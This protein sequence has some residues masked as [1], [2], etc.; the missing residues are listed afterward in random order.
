[1]LLT[2]L[3]ELEPALRRGS[4]KWTEPKRISQLSSCFVPFHSQLYFASDDAAEMF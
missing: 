1:M 2:I 4:F 3:L